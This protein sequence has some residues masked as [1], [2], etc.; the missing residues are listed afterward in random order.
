MAMPVM[1]ARA[2]KSRD[3]LR[4]G[5]SIASEAPVAMITGASSGIGAVFA[6][7]LRQRGFRSILVARR[8][9]R[10][11]ELAQE[12]GPANEV[13]VADLDVAGD[14]ARVERAIV[15]SP[16]LDL[17][18]NNAG[19]GTKGLFWE[20]NLERQ[21]EMHRVHV[22]AT[23]RLTHAALRTMV[24]RKKGAVISV[25]SVAGFVTGPES[26]SYS[27]T[28]SWINMFTEGL[29]ME[30]RSIRS[31]VQVQALCPG[32]TYTEFHDVAKLSRD[33]IPKWLWLKADDVV[34]CSL[35]GL[36]R[37]QWL[38]VPSWKYKLGAVFFRHFREVL[39]GRLA[40]PR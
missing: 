12:L 40:R 19:F 10:L 39:R 8:E 18:V 34:E 13:M 7:K 15:E 30:L 9:D 33:S 29:H 32:F 37:R 26:V 14:L 5:S 28:K 4:M 31:P 20:S 38:V 35:R 25:S 24:P 21:E 11:R 17:L 23:V 22:M 3:T 6:R 27:A 1:A 36:D 2:A 16:R